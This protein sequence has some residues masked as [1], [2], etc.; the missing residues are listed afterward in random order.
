MIIQEAIE[1]FRNGDAITIGD[2]QFDPT[3]FDEIKLETGDMLF[4]AEDEEQGVLLTI[5]EESEEVVLF[6][7]VE[8][9]IEVEEEALVYAG[10]DY[11]LSME[12]S[13]QIMIDDQESE[14]ISFRDFETGDGS[15][16]K[17]VEY[18]VSGDIR[19]WVGEIVI[20]EDLKEIL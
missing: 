17:M 5:D 13:G 18:E 4:F 11:E 12:G 7:R 14:K 20:E 16:F 3:S 9:E 19:N 1:K 2:K 8:E 6:Q 10:E 15:K